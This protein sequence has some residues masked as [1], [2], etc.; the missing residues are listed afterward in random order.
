M[1][2]LRNELSDE[3][4]AEQADQ[5]EP[6][7]GRWSQQEQL[8]AAAVDAL[9]R[10]EYTLICANSEKRNRPKPP[11]PMRR[12]GAKARPTKQALTETQ[13]E[14]LFRIINGGAA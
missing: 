8:L 4:L 14:R 1:T 10:V 5:G 6:E 13:A 9:R 11:E 3:E 2:S 7:K 12:P